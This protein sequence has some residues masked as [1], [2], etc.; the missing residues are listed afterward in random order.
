LAEAKKAV[1]RLQEKYKSGISARPSQG[2]TDTAYQE[3]VSKLNEEDL[4]AGLEGA[5]EL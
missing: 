3:F 4:E 1:A 2:P 5:A